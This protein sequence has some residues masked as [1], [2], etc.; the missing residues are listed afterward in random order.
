M[1]SSFSNWASRLRGGFTRGEATAASNKAASMEAENLSKSASAVRAEA[2]EIRTASSADKLTKASAKAE[3]KGISNTTYLV[4]IA[5]FTLVVLALASWS[6][7][8]GARLNINRITIINTTNGPL[9]KVEYDVASAGEGGLESNFG[10]RVGDYIEFDQPTPTVPNLSGDQQVVA[11]EGDHTF[12]IKPDPM[13]QTAG[14]M[15]IQSASPT[16][17]PRAGTPSGSPTPSPVAGTPSGSSMAGAPFG[18]SF[19]H[20]ATVHSSFSNQLTGQLTDG[21]HILGASAG[22][23]TAEVATAVAA[24]T[25]VLITTLTPAGVQVIGAAANAAGS[26]FHAVSPA[27]G[28]AFCDIVPFLCNSTIWWSLLVLCICIFVIG[29]VLKLKK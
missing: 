18:S 10:L 14:G 22:A 4:G 23:V 19:W 2:Q 5:G 1:G 20:G 15:G 26:A 13:L 8:D 17:S 12:Y 11:V 28:G 3:A 6:S 29:I 27:I 16:P 7:T 9:V 21:I 25:T 24:S